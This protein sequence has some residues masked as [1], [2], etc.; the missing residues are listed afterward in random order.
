MVAFRGAVSERIPSAAAPRPILIV[1]ASSERVGS[2]ALHGSS[3][4]IGV[5]FE[6]PFAP[7]HAFTN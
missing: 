2:C 1:R 5:A 6:I 3:R 7:P 4:E